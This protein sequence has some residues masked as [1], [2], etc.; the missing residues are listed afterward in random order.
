[1]RLVCG[2][3]EREFL[4][5]VVIGLVVSRVLLC[6]LRALLCVLRALLCMLR[7]LLCLLRALLCTLEGDLRPLSHHSVPV[8]RRDFVSFHRPLCVSG[9][10]KAGS[11]KRLLGANIPLSLKVG[12]EL[13]LRLFQL[14]E[15]VRPIHRL[16]N[17]PWT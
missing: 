15:L 1:M 16:S 3:F 13:S 8:P 4:A 5:L 12:S 2:L 14:L 9:R 7:A 6:L 10:K 17:K 11:S